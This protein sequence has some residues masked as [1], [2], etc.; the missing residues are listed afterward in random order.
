MHTVLAQIEQRAHR[1]ADHPFLR[2]LTDPNTPARARIASWFAAAAPFVFGFKDLNA[3]V[4]PYPAD[5]TDDPLKAAINHHLAEDAMHWPW[6][7]HDL[8]KL[9]LDAPMPRSQHLRQLYGDDTVE[10]RR[11][12]Y[13]LCALAQ[14]AATPALRY[15]L[16]MALEAVAHRLFAALLALGTEL[17]HELDCELLYLGPRH[18]ARE[19]G[20]LTHQTDE[21][22]ELFR[23]L[24]LDPATCREALAI[25]DAVVDVI[26]ERWHAF[27]RLA[28]RS[29]PDGTSHALTRSER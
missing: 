3:E 26:E 18:F 5:E 8:E 21:A 1:A 24:R 14:R 6:Y 20:H 15:C 13:R 22:D 10:Q 16:V 19:P 9:G 2:W 7:L 23:C 4:L 25:A 27:L 12:V 29:Q 11:A 17:E 28:Q